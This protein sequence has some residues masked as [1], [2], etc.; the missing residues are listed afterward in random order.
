MDLLSWILCENHFRSTH[1]YF[2]MDA[3][4]LVQTDAGQRLVGHLLRHHRRYLAGAI[5]PDV[6]FRDF[7]NHVVHVD[8]GYW[9][10]A[11]R[12]AHRWYDR[13]LR[14]LR[15][16][17]FSDA[18]HAAGVLSHY[19]TDPMQPLHTHS[20]DLEAVIHRPLEWSVLQSYESILADWRSDDVRVVFRL[21]D[22]SEWLG[23]AVLHGARY[24]NRKL[25]RLLED[26]DLA[27]AVRNPAQGLSPEL[28]AS[29]AEL[30]GIAITGWARVIE[31][32]ARDAELCRGRQ[33][34][35]AGSWSATL[36]AM[37]FAPLSRWRRRGRYRRAQIAVEAIYDEYA[38][39]GRLRNHLPT[40]VDVVQR[41]VRI[42]QQ[43]KAWKSSLHSHSM[44]TRTEP[45]VKLSKVSPHFGQSGTLP[46]ETNREADTDASQT[47]RRRAA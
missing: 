1:H 14:Y 24:A 7:Q 43:E 20:C 41:V 5:D 16:D 23:E 21:S 42:Y 38:A 45:I 29:M 26:F 46:R 44:A 18:A 13:M 12:V 40:E 47:G 11:P 39:N 3:L 25:K 28:R 19:F 35:Q 27:V 9:G 6:R 10:G 33:L 4:P 15:T 17:R 30:F 31:R 8:E 34:P 37:L 32:A 22:R 36:S 2:A